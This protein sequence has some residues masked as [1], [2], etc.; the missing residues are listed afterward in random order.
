MGIA[1]RRK[2]KTNDADTMPRPDHRP[3]RG[4]RPSVLGAVENA[5]LGAVKM[6][7]PFRSA[8]PSMTPATPAAPVAG[9]AFQ[10]GEAVA[11]H[12]AGAGGGESQ[13]DH[14]GSRQG[15]R[16]L[17]MLWVNSNS[18]PEKGTGARGL[19]FAHTPRTPRQ[20]QAGKNPHANL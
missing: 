9:E 3:K 13:D 6:P 8:L 11:E 18:G 7:P 15:N 12:A 20:T 17:G 16:L 4:R 2:A 19:V 5:P 1:T 10:V 14:L